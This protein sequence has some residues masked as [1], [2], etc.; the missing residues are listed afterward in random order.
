[1]N[2]AQVQRTGRTAQSV[3]PPD[4][5]SSHQTAR[6]HATSLF[7]VRGELLVHRND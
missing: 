4:V 6:A 2:G 3:K 7:V 5:G 1:M